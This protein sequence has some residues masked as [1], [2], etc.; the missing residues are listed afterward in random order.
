MTRRGPHQS[1]EGM[2]PL[3]LIGVVL[4]VANGLLETCFGDAV[5]HPE[6]CSQI[7]RDASLPPVD[8]AEPVLARLFEQIPARTSTTHPKNATDDLLGRRVP[9]SRVWRAGA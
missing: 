5:R 9:I 7:D 2:P 8:A 4:L 1:V 3:L 6:G